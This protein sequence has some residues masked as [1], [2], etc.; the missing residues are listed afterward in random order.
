MNIKSFLSGIRVY[1]V[2]ILGFLV[3][4]FIPV[5]IIHG[6]AWLGEKLLPWLN[7]LSMVMI[8]ICIVLLV[9]LAL[10]RPTRP[11][12][13]LGF[14]IASYVFGATGWFMGLLLTWSLWGSFA[15]LIGLLFLGVG[16]VPMGMLATL[17]KGMWPELGFLVVAVVLTFGLRILGHNLAEKV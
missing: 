15:V 2:G 17:L 10:I 3:I 12:A 16:V 11:L 8:V 1:A 4:L 13:G 7:L 5:L 14:F 9:P 6:G